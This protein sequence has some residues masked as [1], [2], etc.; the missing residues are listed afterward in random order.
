MCG[1]R[2]CMLRLHTRTLN[3][4][5]SYVDI[6]HAHLVCYLFASF[7]LT[8]ISI[9][10]PLPISLVPPVPH[11]LFVSIRLVYLFHVCVCAS[12][13]CRLSLLGFASDR[14]PFRDGVVDETRQMHIYAYIYIE[15][16]RWFWPNECPHEKLRKLPPLT[17]L[18]VSIYTNAHTKT[19]SAHAHPLA[20]T[21]CA[22]IQLQ[23]KI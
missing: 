11:F 18:L 21:N 15:V 13:I 19:H 10:I 9:S 20:Y 4:R 12:A 2:I 1:V 17:K 7:V 3:I 6:V 8:S 23:F 14:R 5:T 16:S 22:N